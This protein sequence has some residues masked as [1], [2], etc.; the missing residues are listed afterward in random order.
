MKAVITEDIVLEN[1]LTEEEKILYIRRCKIRAAKLYQVAKEHHIPRSMVNHLVVEDSLPGE[2]IRELLSPIFDARVRTAEDMEDSRF[3]AFETGGEDKEKLHKT[4]DVLKS[5]AAKKMKLSKEETDRFMEVMGQLKVPIENVFRLTFGGDPPARLDPLK[6]RLK[7]GAMPMKQRPFRLA[8]AARRALLETVDDLKQK[9]LIRENM[10]AR[11][12]S[13]M[14]IIPKPKK[15]PSDPNEEV[16]YR[17]VLDLRYINSLTL[18]VVYPMTDLDR[19]LET[20]KGKRFFFAFDMLKGFWQCAVDE[21]SQEYFSFATE[22]KVYSYLRLPQGHIDSAVWFNSQLRKVFGDLIAEG[23]LIVY[24][25][26]VLGCA[27][28][29]EEYLEL[30]KTVILRCAQ[31]GLKI[32]AAKCS[33]G[34]LKAHF[35]GRDIDG[36]GWRYNPRTAEAAENMP[37]PVTAGELSKFLCIANWM[38]STMVDFNRITA[39][40]HDLLENIKASKGGD[41]RKR[42]FERERLVDHGWN[43][44]HEE[45]YYK[46]R[47]MFAERIKVAH[48][49]PKAK[50]F[51]FTDASGK[52]WGAIYTQVLNYDPGKEVWEQDHIPIAVASGTFRGSEL[53]WSTIEREAYPIVK[54]LSMWEHFLQSGAGVSVYTDHKNIADLFRPERILPALGKSQIEK[55][56]RWLYVLSFFKIDS[57]NYIKGE[58]NTIADMLSR[59]GNID[60]KR[61]EDDEAEVNYVFKTAVP[62]DYS[63]FAP[64]FDLPSKEEIIKAQE[65]TDRWSEQDRL[66]FKEATEAG[67]LVRIEDGYYCDCSL[68]VPDLDGLR[69]RCMI[70]GHCGCGGHRGARVVI[71][72]LKG[73]VYWKG[74]ST[75]VEEFCAECLNCLKRKSGR[76]VPRPWASRDHPSVRNE[77]I[78]IDFMYVQAVKKGCHHNYKYI[79]VIKD[80][81]S[82]FCELE[83]CEAA[84]HEV[85]VGALAKWCARYGIPKVVRSDGG[86]HFVNNVVEMLTKRLGIRHSIT[87]A[88]CSFSNGSVERV[89]RDIQALLLLCLNEVKL[90]NEYW[91]E[92]I[93]AVMSVIN[94]TPT[95][96]LG[97]LCARKV[98]LGFEG[99]NPLNILYTV[100]L[101]L[102][103]LPMSGEEI[104]Q[105]AQTLVDSFV[106]TRDSLAEAHKK[107]Q[108]RRNRLHLKHYLTGKRKSRY[109]EDPR[110]REEWIQ[111]E[112]AKLPVEMALEDKFS[113]VEERLLAGNYDVG[114]FVLAAK[115]ISKRQGKLEAIWKG[116]YRVTEVVDPRVYVIQ[117][118]VNGEL[119][120][121]HAIRLR[122]FANSAYEVT[123][124]IVD[125]I[126]RDGNPDGFVDVEKLVDVRFNNDM[127][128]WEFL[129]KWKGF[130]EM[131][132]SWEPLKELRVS[133][134]SEVVQF[135]NRMADGPAKVEL[136]ELTKDLRMEKVAKKRGRKR[137]SNASADKVAAGVST[138][139][140]RVCADN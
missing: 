64:T 96:R 122:F 98:F 56:Y 21:D 59:W 43:K 118:L 52:H 10:E 65:A 22:D 123:E 20:C 92:L 72:M 36:D 57:I 133:I 33:M 27:E 8:P 24:I 85:A 77:V 13:N 75:D 61:D 109:V 50:N 58:Y 120:L 140:S 68:W 12:V 135:V 37:V 7:D 130:D 101:G 105:L 32:N 138:K 29:F 60:Y 106:D 94:S 87:A 63:I 17:C 89:N 99:T 14:L 132:N 93:P 4:L 46:A 80:D 40:L 54:C 6:I 131:E 125:D 28:S 25:D 112:M 16:R 114:D 49:D 19:S 97:G 116:P 104:K 73:H 53:N 74:M 84:N 136:M 9:G 69:L 134:P 81:Y 86:S 44:E 108:D 70:I 38:R 51:I 128:R 30:L 41:R 107:A 103:D 18:P 111:A 31:Y 66:Y 76:T 126:K 83:V 34:D 121:A 137:K 45:V 113:I 35:C 119:K 71:S 15:N 82:G 78:S 88:Y 129:V 79:L 26:D 42:S 23:K 95:E 48:W 55:I 67:K 110:K 90:S 115:P 124:E 139:R 11:F 1:L 91:P 62:R 39:P 3:A 100:E 2:R 5:V 127:I 102:R 47:K 117:H